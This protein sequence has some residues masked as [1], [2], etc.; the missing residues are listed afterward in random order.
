M[1]VSLGL[2]D[3]AADAVHEQRPADQ[4]LRRDHGITRQIERRDHC[5]CHEQLPGGRALD[6][7]EALDVGGRHQ[8]AALRHLGQQRRPRGT[9]QLR[10][11]VEGVIPLR[12]LHVQRMVHDVRQMDEPAVH[13]QHR[14]SAAVTG[15]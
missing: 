13:L 15:R 6:P 5:G 10:V 11:G 9:R 8:H 4:L 3:R 14:V 12:V 2:D 7:P 1:P